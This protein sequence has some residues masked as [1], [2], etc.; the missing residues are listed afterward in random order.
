MIIRYLSDDKLDIIKDNVFDSEE[1]KEILMSPN[2]IKEINCYNL[3]A[4]NLE[5]LKY[6]IELSPFCKDELISK[7]VYG[8]ITSSFIKDK[9]RFPDT[10][11]TSYK[12]KGDKFYLTSLITYKKFLAKLQ[13]ILIYLVKRKASSLEIVKALYDE[14][15]VLPEEES[16]N[17]L[18]SFI[19][20]S[21]NLSETFTFLLKTIGMNAMNIDGYTLVYIKDDKYDVKGI[22]LFRPD[23]DKI[24]SRY[25]K[26][27]YK[28]F[29]LPIEDAKGEVIES[30][31]NRDLAYLKRNIEAFD[32]ELKDYM[33]LYRDIFNTRNIKEDK[34]LKCITSFSNIPSFAISNYNALVE[35]Y[36][37]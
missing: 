9:Y 10:W 13:S 12:I 8:I 1:I 24:E 26:I 32:L 22:Y 11:N 5:Y 19:K 7:N 6:L 33:M 28:G 23:L 21:S 31:M 4:S 27:S 37:Q 20:G 35:A 14:V 16:T 25:N 30:F 29:C 15:K 36:N 18:E 3:D 17:E 2:N 34:K